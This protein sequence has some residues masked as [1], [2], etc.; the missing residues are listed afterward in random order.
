[1]RYIY[2]RIWSFMKAVCRIVFGESKVRGTVACVLLAGLLTASTI[3]GV[4][5]FTREEE[6]VNTAD[7][8]ESYDNITEIIIDGEEETDSTA[9]EE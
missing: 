3:I 5:S 2:G 7:P 9:G 8:I 4:R 6:D 1:M